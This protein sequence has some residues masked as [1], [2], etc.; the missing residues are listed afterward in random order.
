M[1]VVSEINLG[2]VA[3]NEQCIVYVQPVFYQFCVFHQILPL[4]YAYK[5]GLRS[6][7]GGGKTEFANPAANIKYG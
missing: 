6:D 4:L 1:V 2:K 5:Y 3:V 7:T